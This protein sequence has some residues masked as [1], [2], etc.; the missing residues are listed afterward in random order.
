VVAPFA[1]DT[2]LVE[3]GHAPTRLPSARS[4]AAPNLRRASDIHLS[5]ALDETADAR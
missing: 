5:I 3:P 2:L 1:F 4:P